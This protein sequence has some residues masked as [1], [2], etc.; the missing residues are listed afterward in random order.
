MLH[1]LEVA[2][3]RVWMR[4]FGMT[5]AMLPF[6]WPRAFEGSDSS[7]ELVRF[8][9][10]SRHR[11][12]LVVTDAVLL[13][14]GVLDRI[15]AELDMLGVAHVVFDGV[16]PNPTVAQIE[17]GHAVLQ[18]HGC[19]AILAVGG[20]S[21]IDAAKLIGALA[22]NRKPVVKFAGLFRAWR[23]MLPLYAVPTT[24]GTG[25]ECTIVAVVTDPVQRRKLPAVD[26]A[27]MPTA[28]ALDAMLM[29]GLPPH[30]TAATGMDALTH[31][32]EAFVSR[33]ARHRTDV[34][35]LEAA[36]L[37]LRFLERAVAD[38]SDLEARQQMARA[39]HLAGIA[40][41]QAGVG[42]VHAIAHQFGALYHTPHGL[43]NA[44]AMPHV[45]DYSLSHC[46]HR[47][48]R[49]ARHCGVGAEGASDHEVALAFIARIRAM[50]ERFGIPTTLS[51]LR[52]EDVN[53]IAD[54]AIAEARF[55]YAVPRY[56][57][58]AAARELVSR[59]L[60]TPPAVA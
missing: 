49:M 59:M 10:A 1:T 54:A 30:I 3:L 45:L 50:N 28:A 31:A 9:A 20:G 46:S 60:P 12:V 14:L 52:A 56:L 42:Y 19:E 35:A 48:A 33:N 23:G 40:F 41:T 17:A 11:R 55:T 5:T 24:A 25:S 57:R 38:G 8:M 18:A 51:S 15:L 16:E 36:S 4:L 29:T 7:L 26:L 58:R 22:R 2:A 34:K 32:V 27:L 13:K 47:L 6:R 53:A 37:I 44:I 43:A 21:P 39:S